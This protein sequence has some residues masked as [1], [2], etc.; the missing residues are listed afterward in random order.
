M[1]NSQKEFVLEQERLGNVFVIC[2]KE[3]LNISRIEKSPEKLQSTYEKG[4]SVA[5]ELLKELKVFLS[6]V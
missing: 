5:T 6:D 2:S 1:Y 3:S 4:R